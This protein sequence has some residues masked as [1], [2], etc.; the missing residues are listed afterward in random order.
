MI[1]KYGFMPGKLAVFT[2]KLF[3]VMNGTED[4]VAKAN[5]LLLE[6]FSNCERI[7]TENMDL[8]QKLADAVMENNYLTQKQI[9]AVLEKN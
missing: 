6:E 3:E 1:T 5:N 9:R 2:P 7:L 4:Y 8:V